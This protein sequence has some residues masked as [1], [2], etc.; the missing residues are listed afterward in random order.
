[1]MLNIRS[2]VS[3][4]LSTDADNFRQWRSYFELTIKKFGLLDH[5]DGS[6][7][8]A[9]MIDDP[10]WL[11]IDACIVT[12]LYNTIS[13]EI[14]NDVNRPNTCAYSAW[15]AINNQ[16][17]DNSLQRA[18][19][20]QQDF[21]SLFQGD[22]GIAEYCGK[23]KRL[24]D[25]L[26]DCSAPVSDPA[27]VINT[28][29][30]LNNKFSQA[31]AVLSTMNPPPTFLY[32]K[33]YLLQEEHRM[34]H[35][36]KM[37]AQ[38]ALLAAAPTGQ[39]S[40]PAA[41]APP[42]GQASNNSTYDRRK[43]KKAND[44]RNRQNNTGGHGAPSG[45]PPV[46]PG[47][48]APPQWA[49]AHN[50]WQGV[51][52]AWPMNAWR[53]SVLGSKPGVHPVTSAPTLPTPSPSPDA[54]FYAGAPGPL[55]AGLYTAL[56]NM[57]LNNNTGG[58][59]DWFLDTGATS[60]MA[61]SSGILS[62][63]TLPTVHRH[64]VVGNGQF[65]PTDCTGHATIPTFS[66][67]LQLRNV[68]IAPHLVKNLIS[69]RALTRDNSISVEFDPWGFSIKDLRTKT[70]LLRCDS[71]GELSPLRQSTTTS[72]RPSAAFLASTNSSLWHAR[73]GHPGH[74]TLQRLARSI[75]FSCSKSSQH[76]CDACRRGKHVRLPFTQ[77]NN[78]S[79]F[80]FQLLHC[81]V[82]TAPIMSNS[83]FK[84]YLVILDDY[85]HY[86]W[87]FPLRHKSDVLPTLISFHAFVRTQ[88]QKPI[89]CFQTDNGREFDSS[90]SRAFFATHGIA[91]RLTCPYTSQQNGRAER[92]LRTLND[93]VRTLLFQAVIPPTFWPDALAASTYLLNRRPCKPRQHF[94]PFEL[95][96]GTAPDYNNLRVFGCLCYPNLTSTAPHKLAPRSVR[97][98]FLGYPLDQKGYKCY[99]LESKRVIVS[100]HVYFDETCFPFVQGQTTSAAPAQ[101]CAPCQSDEVLIPVEPRPPRRRAPVA[102]P[103]ATVS[104]S[105]NDRAPA[106]SPPASPPMTAQG[107]PVPSPAPTETPEASMSAPTETPTTTA[108]APSATS[109]PPAPPAPP[110]AT[111]DGPRP[112]HP[113]VTR[114]RDGMHMPNPKYAHV[115]TTTAPSPPPS[116]VR[117]A[118]RDPNWKIAMQDEFDALKNNGTWTLVPRPAHANII[119]GKWLFKNKLQ[120]DGSLERRKARWVVRGF[121]QRPGVDFHQTFSPVI[122]PA[123]I[124]TVLHLAATRRWV[125]HQLDVK[126]AFLHGDLAERVYCYQPAGFVD[127]DHPDH[128]CQLVKSL[129]GLKQ[130]PRAWFLRLG[131]QLL[132]MGFHASRSDSSLF[133]YQQ[134]QQAAYLL[135]Y[136]DDIIL[137]ASSSALL[138][139]VVDQ[140]RQAFAIKDLGELHFFLGIQVRRDNAGFHLNQAQYTED[141]LERAGMANCKPA[142]TPVEATPKLSAKDGEPAKDGTFY[143]SITGALQ[144]LT[145]TRPDIAY[146]VNQACLHMH[147][148]RDVHWNLVKRILRYL[149]GTIDTGITI[150]ATPSTTLK[151]YSD[152]DWAGCPDTRRSTSGYC[153]FLS[154]SLVSWS[155]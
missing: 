92:V 89:M 79:Q 139:H 91:F 114:A 37:E 115:A 113:M 99:N 52:Q 94:T 117:A 155:S 83:G 22:M 36:Q 59:G 109:S 25:T 43:K 11:Q 2:H 130:A 127:K 8:A 47:G 24:A 13:T 60:H 85:S 63:P 21:H 10:E 74:D 15:T 154:D 20:A 133:I 9:V 137:T 110:T 58:S 93:G 152:A 140:L 50:P 150:S 57:S 111:D 68:L 144:Y 101:P 102:D 107:A 32:T 66:S 38:T 118:L 4:V 12:W 98:V 35:S 148:P 55:P 97:C 122:K 149:R 28:L 5:I 53:P 128:V 33:S 103:S 145:L 142:S 80:P 135:V 138:G 151:A 31:I 105:R 3:I 96:F 18:V 64:I 62:S 67:S 54:A 34:C 76:T 70:V 14:W 90:A 41:P 125:V 95:L 49:M 119:T 65:I 69:V 84:F 131:G 61:S 72:A 45:G 143:R 108:S 112:Q 16:F 123:T 42:T 23:L 39:A 29:R 6:V 27:L 48:A 78:V 56:N 86:T 19:Y 7:D 116:S 75:G 124:R 81:D 26:Y 153:V 44:G 51:V 134:G 71:S 147:A 46:P 106:P 104:S 100:R 40:R 30:G 126:N 120:P 141:I 121:S 77:S 88:F 129:Y 87:T 146:G 82:W 136:V 17:L 132:R 73:L 1:M